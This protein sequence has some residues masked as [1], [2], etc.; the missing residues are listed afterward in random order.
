MCFRDAADTR[1]QEQ[2][3]GGEFCPTWFL[4]CPNVERV[5]MPRTLP[6]PKGEA[7]FRTHCWFVADLIRR[8]RDG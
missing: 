3:G 5:M 6:S 7:G 2:G 1:A 8:D 4:A